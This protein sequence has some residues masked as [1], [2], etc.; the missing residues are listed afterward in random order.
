MGRWLEE[1]EI[2]E[3]YMGEK[4]FYESAIEKRVG[5][6]DAQSAI[7]FGGLLYFGSLEA[8]GL[9]QKCTVGVAPMKFIF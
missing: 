6:D 5:F 9:E 7:D 8:R 2:L 4:W 1:D 3:Q